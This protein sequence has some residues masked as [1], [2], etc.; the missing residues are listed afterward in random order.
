M[1][2]NLKTVTLDENCAFS[3]DAYAL[4]VCAKRQ[5]IMNS[6][7]RQGYGLGLNDSRIREPGPGHQLRGQDNWT[8]KHGYRP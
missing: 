3:D 2:E 8:S 5:A 7:E 6:P 1:K 4:V